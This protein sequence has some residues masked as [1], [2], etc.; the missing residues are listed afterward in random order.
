MPGLVSGW[1]ITF[2]D[3]T[4]ERTPPEVDRVRVV[5]GVLHLFSTRTYG[6][7]ELVA[8]YALINVRKWTRNRD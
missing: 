3:G 4:E 2:P 6:P 8:S 5:D 1:T 7:D